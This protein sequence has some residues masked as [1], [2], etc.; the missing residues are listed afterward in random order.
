VTALVASSP[1]AFWYLTRGSG[2]V[3]FALLTASLGLGLATTAGWHTRLFPRFAVGRLHRNLTLLTIV[4][5]CIHVVTTIADG[6]AP[7]S[8]ADAVVPFESRYRP[9]WLGLGALAF[10]LLLALVITSLLRLRIGLRAWRF[11]HWLAYAAWPV[12]AFHL[13]GTGSD[14]RTG[15]LALGV[16]VSFILVLAALVGRL[17]GA[18]GTMRLGAA[19]G[20]AGVAVTLGAWYEAGPART[21]WA[22][23]AGTPRTLLAAPA[24]RTV[25]V[26]KRAA[27][28]SLPARFSGRLSGRLVQSAPDSKGLVTLKIEARVSGRVKGRVGLALKGAPLA[29]GGVSMTA[30]GVTFEQA[31][32][33]AVYQGQIVALEGSTVG[34]DLAAPGEHRISL[35]LAFR[36]NSATGA[37]SGVVRCRRR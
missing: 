24:P 22:A 29:G 19:V 23:R 26:V 7:V 30:S 4:F 18:R 10:D 14:A 33:T 27:P 31:G 28:V 21:G 25:R 11:V 2:F 35:E 6:F 15:W 12:A 3:A 5:V 36:I 9:L 20:A 1:S 32:A 17:A 37:V 16:G 8:F 34:A 13:L